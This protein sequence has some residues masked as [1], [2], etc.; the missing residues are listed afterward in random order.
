MDIS[1]QGLHSKLAGRVLG[2]Y[3]TW[4]QHMS[5]VQVRLLPEFLANSST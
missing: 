2:M 1:F 4:E 5:Y 3:V